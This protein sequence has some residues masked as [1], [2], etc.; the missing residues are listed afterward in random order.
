M[1]RV[2][3]GEWG[4]VGGVGL[5]LDTFPEQPPILDRGLGSEKK[6]ATAHSKA[7][8]SAERLSAGADPDGNCI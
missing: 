4:G 5:Y 3:G 6:I 7:R 1:R 2:D 8:F